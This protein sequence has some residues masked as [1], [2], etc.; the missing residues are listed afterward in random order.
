MAF[1][2]CARRIENGAEKKDLWYHLMDEAGN[3]KV[4]PTTAIVSSDSIVAMVAGSDTTATAMANLFWC[5]L[6]HPETY[7]RLRE[8]VDREYPH[9]IDPLLDTS[10]HANMKYLTACIH[11]SLRVLPPVPTSGSR[12]I[13]KGSGGRMIAGRFIPEGTQI[14]VPPY[15]VHSNPENFSPAPDAFIPERWLEQGSKTG[16]SLP[17]G[18]RILK[19]EAFVPFSYGP[20]NC[21]GKN[22]AMNEMMTVGTMLLQRFDFEFADGFD[23]R[24]WRDTKLDI[25]VSKSGPLKVK[26]TPRF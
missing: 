12:F 22:L 2:W 14:F 1:G 21:I 13:T 9:G 15:S 10:R 16:N 8:E 23:R 18:P 19:H 17:G 24:A 11:E 26:I 7:K 6:V 5:L 25:F 3:E 20:A 4:K